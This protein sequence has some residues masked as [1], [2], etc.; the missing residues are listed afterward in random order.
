MKVY[1]Y[2]LSEE[3]KRLHFTEQDPWVVQSVRE[4]EESE[5]AIAANGP[6]PHYAV[7]FDLRKSQDIVFL[8]GKIQAPMGL[9][10]SRCANGFTYDLESRFQGLFTR[11]KSL[12]EQTSNVGVAHSEPTGAKAED[13]EMEL[14][15]KDYIELADVLK[16]QIYLKIPFQPLCKEGCK[17]LCAVCGQDQNTQ[18]CQCHRIKNTALA[19]ALKNFRF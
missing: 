3:P 12:G 9:L 19:N 14:L 6:Q 1:L 11:S 16:E 8:K 18:P 7:D 17:G 13:L 2:E 4:T 5:V 15:E 10:C